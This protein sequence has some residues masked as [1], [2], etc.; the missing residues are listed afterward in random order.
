MSIRTR[1]K[2]LK[3]NPNRFYSLKNILETHSD[4]YMIFGERSNGKTY[5]CL[6]RIIKRWCNEGTQGFILRRWR[7]DITRGNCIQMFAGHVANDLVRYYS[8][9]DWSGIDYKNGAF[10]FTRTVV[11]ERGKED[12]ERQEHPFCFIKALTGVEHDKSISYPDVRLILFDEFIP[13]SGVYLPEEWSLFQNAVSTVIRQRDDVE[14]FLCGNTVAKYNN[15]YFKNMGLKHAKDMK[16]GTIDVYTYG[17]GLK[18]AVEYTMPYVGG[19]ASD[20]YFAF[21]DPNNMIISGE[22]AIQCYPSRPSEWGKIRPKDIV[23]KFFIIFE[24]ECLQ[25]E[26]IDNPDG[27]YIFVHKKTTPLKDQDNDL[28]FSQD[29]DPRVNWKRKLFKPTSKTEKKIVD[30]FKRDKVFYQDNETGDIMNSYIL[31]CMQ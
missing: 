20:K 3:K 11:S 1:W 18:V 13:I 27:M 30:F 28:I 24:D 16:P 6:E 12:V 7:E 29:Y 15:T 14:V 4:Y 2:E 8:H 26:I 31:W 25:C 5:A 10:Y 21:D 23:F 22:W 9:G 19:K 17:N